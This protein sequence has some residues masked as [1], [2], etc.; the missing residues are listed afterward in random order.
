MLDSSLEPLGILTGCRLL[1]CICDNHLCSVQLQ[2][3]LDQAQ[4]RLLEMEQEL[5][6]FQRQR[7]GAQSAAALL[8]N[9]VDQLSQV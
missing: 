7:D 9:S 6:L 3:S 4:S 5:K 8:Q 2:L 1:I